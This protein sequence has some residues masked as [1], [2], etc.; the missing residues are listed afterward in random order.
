MFLSYIWLN[1]RQGVNMKASRKVFWLV[2]TMTLLAPTIVRANIAFI[3]GGTTI[4]RWDTTTNTVS[5][6]VNTGFTLDSLIFNSNNNIISSRIGVN[7]LGSFNGVTDSTFA[8]VGLGNGVADMAL[9]PGGGTLLVGNAFSTS[10]SRVNATTGA[11]VTDLNVLVRPDGIAYDNTGSLFAVLG[12]DELAQL[13][14]VTGAVIN[15]I[16]LLNATGGVTGDADGLTFD[17][18]TGNFYVSN[19]AGSGGG[20]WIVSQNLSTQH[21]I[22]LNADIDG[23]AADGNL[24]YLIQRGV[25]GLQVDLATNLVTLTSPG[26]SGADDIAPLAG[27]GS[28]SIPE[29]A[30]LALLGLG[31]AGL[32][33]SRRKQ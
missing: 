7:Q 14:P 15:H 23:L 31:L 10:I 11:F 1:T 27:G 12:R 26:I 21:L 22:N 17:A 9:E 19:D 18:T 30:T 5:S 3:T 24:L 32:G 28:P 16:T 33:F 29:P 4:W 6:V 25:G 8:S 20:Y 13:N 2:L